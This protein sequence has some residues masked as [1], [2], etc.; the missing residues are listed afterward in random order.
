[1]NRDLL[2]Q[3]IKNRGLK[4]KFIAENVLGCTYQTFYQKTVGNARFSIKE[5]MK[6]KEFLSL[7]EEQYD[8]IFG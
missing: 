7:T 5:S 4:Y 8:E 3:I 2:T 1:M 6:L